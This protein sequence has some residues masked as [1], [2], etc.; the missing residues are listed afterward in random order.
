MSL[1]VHIIPESYPTPPLWVCAEVR[2]INPL[3]HPSVEGFVK[4]SYSVDGSFPD[5]RI[6]VVVTQRGGRPEWSFEDAQTFVRLVRTKGA[7]LVYDIDDD[8]LGAHP[9]PAIEAD[10]ARKR[11]V[12]RFLAS[13]ADLIICSTAPLADRMAWSPAPK[14]VWRN[15]LDER[16]FRTRSAK[17]LHRGRRLAVGYAG[18]PSHLRDLLSV[19]ESLRGAL[20]AEKNRVGL[21]FFGATDA[22]HLQALFG[23]LLFSQPRAADFYHPYLEA[24]QSDVTWDVAIAPLLACPFNESKSDIKFLEYSAFG[25]PGVYS[26]SDA[27]SSVVHQQTGLLA[28]VDDF[29]QSVLTL[30]DSPELR[31]QL[32]KNAYE[33]VMQER[34]LATR[35]R[36]LVSIIDSTM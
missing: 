15:A 24:M 7:K 32:I 36:E 10:L 5:N 14:L 11:R 23:S 1:H 12:I 18:T 35:A 21:E 19:T 17:V 8:L 16:L 27:Y 29:G 34:T 25:F 3:T 33:Y 2:L 20:A 13:E 30:L 6:D 4:T 22:D 26:A 31:T 9:I 28:D